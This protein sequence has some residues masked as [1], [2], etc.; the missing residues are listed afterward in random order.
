MVNSMKSQKRAETLDLIVD[1]FRNIK[2]ELTDEDRIYIREVLE[3][4]ITKTY[5]DDQWWKTMVI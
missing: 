4:L 5:G 3:T 1:V 2:L